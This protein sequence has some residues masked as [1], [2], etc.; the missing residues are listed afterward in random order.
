[1][2]FR[3]TLQLGAVLALLIALY[4]G[5]QWAGEK[6]A[7]TVQEAKKIFDFAPESIKKLT[8]LR[9]DEKPTTGEQKAAGDWSIVEPNPQIKALDELWNRV[10]K[11]AA[12]LKSERTLPKDAL[13]LE[14]Y[15]LAIPRLTVTLET[16]GAPKVLRF[17]YLEPTQTY[18]YAR[19]D[20]GPV[21]LAAKNSVFELD[22][23]LDQLRDAFIVDNR[24]APIV[25]FEFARIMTEA[26]QKEFTNPPPLGEESEAVI[27]MERPDADH[28][29]VQIAPDHT[30]ANQEKVNEI[31]S[32][33]QFARGRNY[34]ESPESLTDYG[35]DPASARITVV[36]AVG[37]NPQTFL[38]GNTGMV[39]KEGGVYVQRLG[40]PGVFMMDG[41]ILTLFPKSTNA[42]R[43][44]H[45]MTVPAKDL[46]KLVYTGKGH[47]YTLV[48]DEKGAWKM[49]D[50][51]LDDTDDQ[52][53][54]NYLSALKMLEAARFYPGAPA[55]FGL[56]TPE[57]QVKL[58]VAGNETPVEIRLT[59]NA[60][61]PGN[62]YALTTAGEIAGVQED[63][64][65]F[66][67]TDAQAFRTRSLLRFPTSRAEKMSFKYD[68]VDYQ[69][70]KLHNRWLVVSPEHHFMPNQTDAENLLKAVAELR[71]IGAEDGQAADPSVYGFDAPRFTFSV[72]LAS[73][74]S[75]GTPETLGPLTI[76]AVVPNIDQQR[77]AQTAARTGVFRIKQSFVEAVAAAVSGIR[78]SDAASPASGAPA[79]DPAAAA[80]PEAPVADPPA[81]PASAAPAEPVVP[82]AAGEAPPAGV[83][84]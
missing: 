41:Q 64:I 44:R 46:N 2:K 9:L 23:P 66:L 43:E 10:A 4:F 50:P 56:E 11:N 33:I 49:T 65:R 25:R 28:P 77:F 62:Y 15:G 63:H 7:Q 55:D 16:E 13:D 26:Q 42:L 74:E 45:L 40:E 61:E 78:P 67:Q 82:S 48:K 14:A 59:P 27:I 81:A 1:M 83:A 72:T 3:H 31:V 18:R 36:D 54:S 79:P 22:R 47:S 17:G 37:G 70:E 32:E 60:A 8:I 58:Y 75:G 69:L 51:A 34:V 73:E 38:F 20:D 29:W 30:A 6:E 53:V 21:F 35:L 5:L 71:A 80:T 12:E 68:G 39:G 76:G 19:L 57:V 52:Y 24:E 84:R